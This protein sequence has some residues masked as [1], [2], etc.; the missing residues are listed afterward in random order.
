MKQKFEVTVSKT[1]KVKG[2][3][4]HPVKSWILVSTYRGELKIWDYRVSALI[5]SFNI[6]NDKGE[7]SELCIRCA[8]FHPTQPLLVC[9]GHDKNIHIFNYKTGRKTM[10]L[11]GHADYIRTVYFHKDRPWVV[12]A[13]D[14]TTIRIWN[15]Q[16]KTQMIMMTGH[17]HYVMCAKF[18]P[19]KNLIVS[20][21]LDRTVRIWD[22]SKLVEKMQS[23]SSS[24]VASPFDVEQ[25]SMGDDHD[26][27]VNWV[28]IDEVNDVI[29]SAGD[30]RK[31]RTWKVDTRGPKLNPV[32]ALYGHSNNVCCVVYNKKTDLVVSNSEDC[33][34]K[35]WNRSTSIAIETFKRSGDKQ[36]ILDSHPTLPIIAAGTE[37]SVIVFSLDQMVHKSVTIG[38]EV[39]FLK[40]YD[41]YSMHLDDLKPTAVLKDIN[42]PPQ[43][44]SLDSS[45]AV[46]LIHNIHNPNKNSFLLKFNASKT[47][48][49]RLMI[50]EIDKK[51]GKAT[52]AQSLATNGTYIGKQKMA[53]VIN[54]HVEVTDTET[55]L[56]LGPL[57]D[58][59]KVEDIFQGGVGKF[60]YRKGNNAV[61]YDT[62][63]K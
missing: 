53:L 46:R 2:L 14:D 4:F 54:G 39:Y 42:R 16:S 30:D 32:D 49:S 24:G 36:W 20:G 17:T 18:H 45:K 19:T 23:S 21:S 57:G 12:S 50:V 8:S 63:T 6:I 10:T 55:M 34:L 26:N 33:T 29:Y 22:Y 48:E 27:G 31:V 58:L 1:D 37:S 25:V 40:E 44:T 11:S 60:I 41:L 47:S 28:H 52:K 5:S 13:S 35:V 59:D 3:C 51:T 43:K 56:S 15:F 38:N 62:V 9:G 7:I 61:L